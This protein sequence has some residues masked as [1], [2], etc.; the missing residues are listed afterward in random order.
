[1]IIRVICRGK[2]RVQ[3]KLHRVTQGNCTEFLSA[4]I[5]YRVQW[6][7]EKHCGTLCEHRGTLCNFCF[8]LPIN[9]WNIE[10]LEVS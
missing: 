6:F 4:F 1:M 8:K 10:A 2:C 3:N 5:I 9:E 7:A